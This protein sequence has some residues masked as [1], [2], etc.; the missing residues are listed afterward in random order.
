VEPDHKA[1][2]LAQLDAPHVAALNAW[3]R[4][5]G[6]KRR[7]DIPWFDPGDAGVGARV[8]LLLESPGPKSTAQSGSG[9][10]SVDNNDPTAENV[11]TFRRDAGLVEGVLHWNAVPWYLGKGAK[12]TEQDLNRALGLL[13]SLLLLL[14]ALEI[15]V[16]MGN[17]AKRLWGRYCNDRPNNLVVIPTWH[18]SAL[19]LAQPGRREEVVAAMNRVHGMVDTTPEALPGVRERVVAL[20]RRLAR[21]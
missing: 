10:I 16:P 20:G 11:W 7:L 13:R 15:V 12:V 17:S 5:E 14:P 3:V 21:R 6:Q 18:P 19:G 4:R 2:R 9:I 1:A 8:V